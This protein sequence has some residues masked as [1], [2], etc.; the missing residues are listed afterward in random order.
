M[1]R[2]ELTELA[3]QDLETLIRTRELPAQTYVHVRAARWQLSLFPESG[4][5]LTG[6]Y[7]G[8][9][10]AEVAWGWLA[11][12]YEYDRS[13]DVVTV[14]AFYDIRTRGAPVD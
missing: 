1:T 14:I 12:V 5:A 2:G 7:D 11:L 13:E 6:R 10:A 8:L 4:Q 9:H 3:R